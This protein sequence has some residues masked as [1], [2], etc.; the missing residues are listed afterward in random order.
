MPEG[1]EPVRPVADI[2]EEATAA[3]EEAFEERLQ[4]LNSRS[5]LLLTK[6]PN[7]TFHDHLAS[8]H[9]KPG[10]TVRKG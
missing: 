8:G 10:H 4:Q 5:S 7:T 2:Q 6:L 3:E 9:K 1:H